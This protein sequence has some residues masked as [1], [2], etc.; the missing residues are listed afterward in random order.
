MLHDIGKSKIP[1]E[2]L[3][4]P[5]SLDEEEWGLMKKHPLDRSGDHPQSETVGRDQSEDGDRY[6][7]PP[8][9]KRSFWIPQTLPEKEGESLRSNHSD[10]GFL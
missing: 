6:L 1:I 2:I 9:E 7:R 4:K 3:N 8:L 10:C 5:A